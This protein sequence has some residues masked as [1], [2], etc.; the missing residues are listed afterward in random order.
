[1]TIVYG[2]TFLGAKD[3]IL[4]QLKSKYPYE[5]FEELSKVSIYITKLTLDSVGDLFTAASNIK[6]FFKQCARI[7]A[8]CNQ[9]MSWITPMGLPVI[10]PYVKDDKFDVLTSS[11][12]ELKLKQHMENST[13]N[14]S[15]QSTAFPPNYIHSLD[16]TH[17]MFTAERMQQNGLQFA[18]V[19]DSFWTHA[20]DVDKMNGFLREEF[21][22]IYSMPLLE[23]LKHDLER[24]FPDQNFPEIPKKG[25]LDLNEVLNSQYFFS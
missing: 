24:R 3:Q 16:S 20:C 7:V 15:K 10:Q 25:N 18:S 22:N 2:V 6:E 8:K 21:V 5:S 11:A 17:L 14:L 19:H 23:K 9:P 13:I 4:K 1:M 12:T